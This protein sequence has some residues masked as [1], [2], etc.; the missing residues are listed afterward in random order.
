M[1]LSQNISIDTKFNLN[2]IN[3]TNDIINIYTR[4]ITNKN[5]NDKNVYFNTNIQICSLKPNR[6]INISDI[7][8][9]KDYG[10]NNAIYSLGSWKY[11]AIN[12]DFNVSSLNNNI[13]NGNIH[14]HGNGNVHGQGNVNG[15]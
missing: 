5:K 4:D 1:S 6:F 10:Y 12:T 11:K 14:G 7:Y 8:I 2:V 9:N 15:K 13:K 3:N